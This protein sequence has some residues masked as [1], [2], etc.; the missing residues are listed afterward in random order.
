MTQEI[1]DLESSNTHEVTKQ[2]I[3][4]ASKLANRLWSHLPNVARVSYTFNV[5]EGTST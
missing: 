5:P 3:V 2:T 1:Y 4:G